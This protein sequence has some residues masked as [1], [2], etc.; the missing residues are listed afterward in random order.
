MDNKSREILISNTAH[1]IWAA[2]QL[3]PGEGIEDGVMRIE[4]ILED[5]IEEL[6]FMED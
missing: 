6:S 5:L 4:I 3:M 2:S 1:E